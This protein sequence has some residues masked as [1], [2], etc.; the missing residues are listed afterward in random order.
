MP[1]TLT[2]TEAL[3]EIKTLGKRMEKKRELVNAHI[4][5]NDLIRDPFDKDGGSFQVLAQELQ[6]LSDLEA[7]LVRI[8]LAIQAANHTISITLAGVTRTIAG[9]LTWRKEVAPKRQQ[10][11]ASLQ[12]NIARIRKDAQQKGMTVGVGAAI[13]T[14]TAEVN[15][16]LINVDEL[17]LAKESETLVT[18]L[19]DLDGQLSLKNATET[20][21]IED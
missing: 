16:I 3:A 5:R 17:E 21:T 8:R 12:S 15:N 6:S 19:G 11:V 7:R 14:G 20:I 10:F 9:W 2:I 18:I 1:S 4:A 13:S